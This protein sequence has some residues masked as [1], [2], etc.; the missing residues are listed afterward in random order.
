M[1][2]M[3]KFSLIIMNCIALFII[4]VLM[5]K[6]SKI[7]ER[8]EIRLKY[9]SLI[10]NMTNTVV[11]KQSGIE[12]IHNDGERMKCMTNDMFILRNVQRKIGG[13]FEGKTLEQIPVVHVKSGDS[14]V[15]DHTE[16]IEF[17]CG[18]N[19][20]KA[21]RMCCCDSHRHIKNDAHGKNEIGPGMKFTVKCFV[22]DTD[23]CHITFLKD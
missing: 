14:I 17:D 20:F 9:E 5:L 7:Q 21:N 19:H 1:K 16:F 3:T 6:P 15:I 12:I 4:T 11:M 10:N 22:N 8:D 23:K 18:E 2:H 13:I